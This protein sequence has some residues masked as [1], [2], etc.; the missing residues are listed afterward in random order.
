MVHEETSMHTHEPWY[1]QLHVQLFDTLA[2]AQ[3][4]VSKAQKNGQ[5]IPED[6]ENYQQLARDFSIAI[7]VYKPKSK[8]LIDLCGTTKNL[9]RHS[10]QHVN[11]LHLSQLW[12]AAVA[13]ITYRRM[14]DAMPKQLPSD[15]DT[16]QRLQREYKAHKSMWQHLLLSALPK[17]L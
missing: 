17:S 2:Q 3:A 16:Q 15:N 8:E 5:D 14:L 10:Y 7:S 4:V 13:T 11:R 6:D 1:G 12:A 9:T